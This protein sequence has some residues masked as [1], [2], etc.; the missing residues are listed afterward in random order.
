MDVPQLTKTVH[1]AAYPSIDPA[2]PKLSA[3][4][5]TIIISGGAGGI[6]FA[7]AQGFCI[8][9]AAR[10]IIL[11]RRQEA[12]DEAASKLSYEN[13]ATERRT[14]IWTYLLDMKDT[15]ASEKV[16]NTIRARLNE[17]QKNG[18]EV[19]DA[20][21]LILSAANLAQG[22]TSLEFDTAVY[23]EAFETNVIGNLNLVRAFLA[24]EIPGIPFTTLGG[25]K[26]DV[27]SVPT[28]KHKKTILDISSIAAYFDLSGQGPYSTTKLAFTRAMKTLQIEV[29]LIEGQPI[30]IHSF[31]PGAIWTPG[32]ASTLP[33]SI[34][35]IF[36]F[37]DISLPQGFAVWLASA[38]AEFLKGRFLFSSWDVDELI[39]LKDVFA[40]DPNFGTITLKQ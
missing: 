19:V 11:A 28:P 24:P 2:N 35:E 16:F 18:D 30:R 6:G 22:K 8:A 31:H 40:A 20:D 4:G 5:K 14:E 23:R 10:V 32:A 29:D 12:L 13:E 36:S 38:E 34:R 27:S 9:G 1:K 17:G 26:K 21:I 37:D 39:A 25:V 7:I 33:E 3:A 15:I